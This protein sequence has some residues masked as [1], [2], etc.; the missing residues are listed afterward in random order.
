MPG[1]DGTG[2]HGRGPMTGGGRGFCSSWGIG[3]M[4]GSDRGYGFGRRYGSGMGMPYA[5]PASYGYAG[6]PMWAV[7]GAD[8]YASQMTREQEL[9]FLKGQADAIKG[10]LEQIDARTKELETE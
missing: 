10:Q 1:F 2:P 3:R 9:D 5:R 8:P 6:A 7:P 4:Y